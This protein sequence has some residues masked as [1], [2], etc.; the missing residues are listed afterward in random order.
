MAG[1]LRSSRMSENV[2]EEVLKRGV[3]EM[4][5]D[6]KGL[7]WKIERCRDSSQEGLKGTVLRGFESMSKVMERAIINIGERMV[8]EKRRRDIGDREIEERLCRLEERMANKVIERK[9]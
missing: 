9:G 5:D 6:M 2:M 7:L 3:V 4:G 8:E 1:R